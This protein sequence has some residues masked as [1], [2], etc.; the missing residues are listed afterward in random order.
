MWEKQVNKLCWELGTFPG[1][2]SVHNNDSYNLMIKLLPAS[3]VEH[4][5][6]WNQCSIQI[7]N[8]KFICLNTYIPLFNLCIFAFHISWFLKRFSL[9]YKQKQEKLI[10]NKHIVN[11]NILERKSITGNH[12]VTYIS[13]YLRKILVERLLHTRGLLHQEISSPW[14]THPA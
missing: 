8:T 1:N 14:D 5:G 12:I 10:I 13:I 4:N 3:F 11:P 7:T 9:S 2:S 6:C